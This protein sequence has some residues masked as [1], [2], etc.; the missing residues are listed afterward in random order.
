VVDPLAS[1]AVRKQQRHDRSELWKKAL[2]RFNSTQRDARRDP[3][4]E[5]QRKRS[6]R[7][8]TSQLAALGDAVANARM[9][10]EADRSKR[11]RLESKTHVAELQRVVDAARALRKQ[12][13]LQA[14]ARREAREWATATAHATVGAQP[15]GLL[16]RTRLHARDANQRRSKQRNLA[17]Q[18]LWLRDRRSR[19]RAMRRVRRW[20]DPAAQDVPLGRDLLRGNGV[21]RVDV[22]DTD[23][24][25]AVRSALCC[26]GAAPQ[27]R[28]AHK[29]QQT[30]ACTRVVV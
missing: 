7:Q 20:R 14:A 26:R 16:P 13:E 9:D 5:A 24:R 30:P 8:L 28:G 11:R 6:E 25:K 17:R 27:G 23:S 22:Q 1:A 3:T 19:A 15:G 18:L 4:T 2:R 12:L 10:A 21:L 29:I